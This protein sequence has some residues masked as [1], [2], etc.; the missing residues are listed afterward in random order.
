MPIP[1][2]PV[3]PKLFTNATT[4]AE[5]SRGSESLQLIWAVPSGVDSYD[6]RFVNTITGATDTRS[7]A[8]S[9][10]SFDSLTE[11]TLYQ[12]SIRAINDDGA[13]DFSIALSVRTRPPRPTAPRLLSIVGLPSGEIS[14][15]GPDFLFLTFDSVGSQYKY[16]F[17]LN[18]S[19]VRLN[20]SS[21]IKNLQPNK[22]YKI[23]VRAH[24]ESSNNASFWSSS[25][26][27]ITR[28]STPPELDKPFVSS[29]TFSLVIQW[30][31]TGASGDFIQ[32]KQETDSVEG[33][34]VSNGSLKSSHDIRNTNSGNE[35]KYFIRFVTPSSLVSGGFNRSFWSP[36]VTINPSYPLALHDITESAK[37]SSLGR[38]NRGSHDQRIPFR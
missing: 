6:I 10:G 32:A 35:V 9:G 31:I 16:D 28:P 14:P 29:T 8:T 5:Q 37:Y 33:L 21:K 19:E 25:F 24:D 27:T 3:Q 18:L 36:S 23:E 12:I 4:P 26:N 34:L 20:P 15:R 13:S 38:Q 30:N 7:N 1:T 17:R 2:K 11:N 22:K